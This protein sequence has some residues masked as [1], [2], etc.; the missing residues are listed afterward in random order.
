ME[1][2]EESEKANQNAEPDEYSSA[3]ERDRCKRKPR[4]AL[5]KNLSFCTECPRERPSFGL[6]QIGH[7]HDEF[8]DLFQRSVP[9]TEQHSENDA[10]T[11]GDGNARKGLFFDLFC[12]RLGGSLALLAC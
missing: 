7:P 10:G 12:E 8:G 6:D 2:K 5:A 9:P 3:P 1:G 4:H 11:G